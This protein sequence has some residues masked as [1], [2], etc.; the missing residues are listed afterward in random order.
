MLKYLEIKK[1]DDESIDRKLSDIRGDLFTHKM[2]MKTSGIEKPHLIKVA[3]KDI[4][5]L[6]TEKSKRKLESQ[7]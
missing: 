1:M 5:R 4:A 3:K 6:L 2:Q 7:G